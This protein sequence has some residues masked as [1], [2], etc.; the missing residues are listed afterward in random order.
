MIECSFEL[1]G[2]S[3]LSFSKAIQSDKEEG[4]THDAFERR[5][6][7][8]RLHT[9]AEGVA[10]IPAM[11]IKNMMSDVAAYRGEKIPGEGN[12]KYKKHFEAGIMCVDDLLLGVGADDFME[13]RLFVPAD[14]RRG[15]GKK[16]W[17]SFPTLQEGWRCKGTL[18]V[19][20]HR[21]MKDTDKVHDYLQYG[22]R[23]IGV[24]RFRP[25]NN[26]TYGRFRVEG[27]STQQVGD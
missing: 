6:W 1:F 24:G 23:L 27:W 11:A 21:L 25:R 7:R 5:T 20:D 14:G 22:G 16:V 10:Y 13:E 12:A 15:G 26:G 4:E 19:L 8:E 9:N 3:P 18:I 17:K 2:I